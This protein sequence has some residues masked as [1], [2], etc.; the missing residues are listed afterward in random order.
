[1]K[2]SSRTDQLRRKAVI[3]A[4][5]CAIL[6]GFLPMVTQGHRWLAFVIIGLQLTL[7]VMAMNFIVQLRRLSV[8]KTR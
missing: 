1:M 5:F 2:M 6:G 4:A 7:L 8:K 3:T